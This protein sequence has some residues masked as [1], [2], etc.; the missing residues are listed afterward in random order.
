MTTKTKKGASPLRLN[1]TELRRELHRADIIIMH[2]VSLMTP[3]TQ[4]LLKDQLERCHTT[5]AIDPLG[6]DAR[7]QAMHR[8]TPRRDYSRLALIVLALI[9]GIAWISTQTEV[10][11]LQ[12]EAAQVQG[13]NHDYR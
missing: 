9:L 11:I 12:A 7:L 10:Q 8:I 5:D 1:N 4:E 2:A 6:E 3:D 13:D